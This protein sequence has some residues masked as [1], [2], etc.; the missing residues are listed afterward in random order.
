MARGDIIE[1]DQFILDR[2]LELHKMDTDSIRVAFVSNAIVPSQTTPDP[3]WGVGGG[4]NFQTNEQAGGSFPANGVILANQS[5]SLVGGAAVF[6]AD[7]PAVYAA[8]P[9]NPTDIHWA[10]IYNDTAAGKQCLYA[11]DMGGPIDASLADLTIVWD[12][13]GIHSIDQAP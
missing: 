13:S 10:I 2:G 4:T 11:M 8:N 12:A 1:V 6:D 9:G 5:W 3:R 7:D